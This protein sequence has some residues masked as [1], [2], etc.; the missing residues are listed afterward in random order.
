MPKAVA[1]HDVNAFGLRP[2]GA[3]VAKG[4]AVLPEGAPAAGQRRG[5]V[6]AAWFAAVLEDL[7]ACVYITDPDG[8]V[9]YA[10][11]QG[12]KL[13]GREPQPGQDRFTITHRMLT[14][15]GVTVPPELSPMAI[16]LRDGTPVRGV[17][18]LLERPDGTRVPIMPMPTPLFDANGSVCGGFMLLIDI[19]ARRNAEQ[20][21]AESYRRDGLTGLPNRPALSAHLNESMARARQGGES[22]LAMRLDLDSFKA[23]NDEHGHSLGDAVLAEAARRLRGTLGDAFVARTGGDEFMIVVPAAPDGDGAHHLIRQACAAFGDAFVCGEHTLRISASGGC[24]RFPQDGDDEIRLVAAANAALKLAKAEGPGT[25]RLF[26]SVEQGREQERQSFRRDLRA[27]IESQIIVPHYQPLFRADGSIAGFEALARW[28][29]ERRGLVAPASF[30]AAAEEEG[31]LIA[32][33]DAYILRSACIEAAGWSKPLRISVN[34]SALEFQSG[35]LPGRVESVL[36]ETGLDPE[37]LELEITEG[38]MVTDADSA[39]STFAKLRALG[40]RIALDDFGTGY[41]SLSYLHRFPLTTLKIDRSFI[42]KLGVTLE[43][44]AITRAIIQLGH[45]LGFEVVAEGVETPEQ[46]DFLVQ[47]GCDLAQGFLLGRPEHPSAY[48]E[49]TGA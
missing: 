7:P 25:V 31:A 12:A 13:V 43:S 40:V 47:E 32:A 17:E 27:A 9:I 10:N 36:A 2:T 5:D 16:T 34:I 19:S 33:L 23:L 49:L 3:P 6:S 46:L 29:D 8:L 14:A 28:Q 1:S 37:R 42:A 4:L 22:L 15:E 45:A 18:M 38:V 44:V 41:S 21:L 48:P 35:D 39:M 26:D 24:A 11:R 30:I 20:R